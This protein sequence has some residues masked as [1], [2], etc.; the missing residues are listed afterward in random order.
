MAESEAKSN[1]GPA[2]ANELAFNY[3]LELNYRTT[4]CINQNLKV[5]NQHKATIW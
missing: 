2:T 4:Y 5:Q 3:I 1:V